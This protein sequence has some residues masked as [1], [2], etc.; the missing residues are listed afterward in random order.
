MN[1][2]TAPLPPP[3]Q[4]SRRPI[5][6]FACVL[7][8]LALGA[9]PTAR[10]DDVLTDEPLQLCPAAE[11]FFFEDF[12]LAPVGWEVENTAP[13]TSYDW[14]LSTAPLPGGRPGRAYAIADAAVGDCGATNESARHSLLSPPVEIPPGA[15][16]VT[17]AFTHYVAT[18]PGV[19]G[20]AVSISIDGSP[21]FALSRRF[22]RQNPYN[23]RLRSAAAGSTNPLAGRD[24]FS[25][26]GGGWGGT[27]V[28]L[29]GLVAPGQQVRIRFDF[30]KD[31]CVGADGW[32]VDD[33]CLIRCP[34]CNA[35]GILDQQTFRYVA[36][37]PTFGPIGDG[38]PA[39]F[40]LP[41]PP[42]AAGVVVLSATASADLDA[43]SER[44][45]I[46]VN[47]TPLGVLFEANVEHCPGTPD[48]ERFG[49]DP[50]AWNFLVGGGNATIGVDAQINVDPSACDGGSYLALH[51]AYLTDALDCNS[52]DIPDAC[53]NPAPVVTQPPA[54]IAANLGHP[55]QFSVVAEGF[56]P[57]TYQW[58]HEGLPLSDDGRIVGASSPTL[59]INAVA[60]LDAG[61]YSV[62]IQNACGTTISDSAPLTVNC[63]QTLFVAKV[64]PFPGGIEDHCGYSAS[65]HG[66]HAAFG[67]IGDD[68]AGAQVGAVHVADEGSGD[69]SGRTAVR[70]TDGNTLQQFGYS[71]AIDADTLLVGAPNDDDRGPGAG[72]VYVYRLI[73]STWSL[74]QKLF[75]ADTQANDQFGAAVALSGD[76]A[77][78][79]AY[80]DNNTGGQFAGAAY[81]FDR[82][83]NIWTQ[84]QKILAAD[85]REFDVFGWSVAIDADIAVVGTP[86][87]DSAT[88]ADCGAAYLYQRTAGVWA[89]LAKRTAA[90]AAASDFFGR[91]VAIRG[92]LI[93]VGAYG[94]EDPG[95]NDTGAAY[96]LERQG[97]AW[98]Q[99]ARLRAFDPAD[100][101]WFGWSVAIDN[102][103]VL[104]GA[105]RDDVAGSESGSAYVYE[106]FG[107]QWLHRARIAPGDLA[108]RDNFGWSVALLGDIAIGGAIG[109][110]DRATSA[111]S[112]TLIDTAAATPSIIQ[113][114][115]FAAQSCAGSPLTLRTAVRALPAAAYQWRKNGVPIA[116]ATLPQL[117]FAAIQPSDTGVY[118]VVV[119]NACGMVTSAPYV[120]TVTDRGDANCDGVVNNFDVDAFVLAE[121]LGR[122]AW[123]AEYTCDYGCANDIDGNGLVN[124][125]DIDGFVEC[126]ANLGCP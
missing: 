80:H 74:E 82:T 15:T 126:V 55:A 34:D 40:T 8:P 119:S 87:G 113:D 111:G 75:G 37:S 90:D 68:G 108:P 28:D 7:A 14:Q 36:A 46:L 10:A 100:S 58:R 72:A 89:P 5:V 39:G 11:I 76:T 67:A 12:E 71:V 99:T 23:A 57:L 19:D 4:W 50:A 77:L 61:M 118:D 21:Y 92:D 25:G 22:F 84:S 93:V 9:P 60:T 105:P 1:R 69:W 20:G 62:A 47:G 54:A 122:D 88:V 101:D 94:H 109:D 3:A 2:L 48:R 29:S 41:L 95:G 16:S 63:A 116:G 83:V 49:V 106:K 56:A 121:V 6:L 114:A 45:T 124:S 27:I 30:G 35:D 79:G 13:P 17:L 53:E 33:V 123:E 26:V 125:F 98:P 32:Y 78:I 24:A 70:P 117:A 103:R 64:L 104:I 66:R 59:S 38:Q 52:N 110:N 91:S 112:A 85:A 44:I 107:G 65:A 115:A 102:G 97:G 81:V 86:S 18:Q 31:G 43:P 120:V 96:V 51:I 73:G 42:R